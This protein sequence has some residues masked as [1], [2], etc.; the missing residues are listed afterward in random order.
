MEEPYVDQKTKN[1][2]DLKYSTI[3]LL[4]VIGITYIIDFVK[5]EISSEH[6]ETL[7]NMFTFFGGSFLMANIMQSPIH[8]FKNAISNFLP[9]TEKDHLD[10]LLLQQICIDKYNNLKDNILY[11]VLYGNYV[12]YHI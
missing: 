9:K 6:L 12:S 7:K 11:T 3:K 8:D 5:D 2:N 10:L 1:I 4:V